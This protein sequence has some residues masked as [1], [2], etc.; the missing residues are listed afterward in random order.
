MSKKVIKRQGFQRNLLEDKN[1]NE[2][3]DVDVKVN[4][5]DPEKEIVSKKEEVEVKVSAAK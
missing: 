2:E 1:A 4:K 5:E 3:K